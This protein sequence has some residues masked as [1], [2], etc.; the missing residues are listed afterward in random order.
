MATNDSSSTDDDANPDDDIIPK[1][2]VRTS[3]RLS[4]SCNDVNSE[5]ISGSKRTATKGTVKS[6]RKR[7]E[8]G[9]TKRKKSKKADTSDITQFI[10]DDDDANFVDD[11]NEAISGGKQT[12]TKQAM[13]RTA[14]SSRKRAKQGGTKQKKSKKADTSDITQSIEDDDANF[15]DDVDDEPTCTLQSGSKQTKAKQGGTK[16]M[17]KKAERLDVTQSIEDVNLDEMLRMVEA[18]LKEQISLNYQTVQQ[19][20]DDLLKKSPIQLVSR[21]SCYIYWQI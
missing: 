7:T 4:Y 17:L 20:L 15:D 13:K 12:A 18:Q 10:E 1:R 3:R 6:S 19:Q 14:K 2:R 8:Q 9:G 11:V 21:S 16:Q 5:A